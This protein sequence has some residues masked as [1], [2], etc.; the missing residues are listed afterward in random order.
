MQK[1]SAIVWWKN[2]KLLHKF[3]L[4]NMTSNN[5]FLHYIVNKEF[6]KDEISELFLGG[7]LPCKLQ[8]EAPITIRFE[9]LPNQ[10]STFQHIIQDLLNRQ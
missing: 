8:L 1:G 7:C 10:I 5:S 2:E 9:R 6:R 4:K 3:M